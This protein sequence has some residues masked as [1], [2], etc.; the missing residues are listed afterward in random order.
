MSHR[1]DVCRLDEQNRKA[2]VALYE[3]NGP[4]WLLCDLEQYHLPNR[5]RQRSLLTEHFS[6]VFACLYVFFVLPTGLIA[7]DTNFSCQRSLVSE[8]LAFFLRESNPISTRLQHERDTNVH[9]NSGR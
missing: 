4:L 9:R 2:H 8:S 5:R 1:E 3:H 7:L 6:H